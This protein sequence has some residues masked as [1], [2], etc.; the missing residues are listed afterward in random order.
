L[1]P[2]VILAI[3]SLF[4]TS[5]SKR[6][7]NTHHPISVDTVRIETIR[8]SIIF[9]DTVIYKTIPGETVIDSVI[10]PCPEVLGY[11][12][13]KVYAETSLAKASAWWD[14]PN[15]KLELIQK[16]TT[17]E[18]RLDRALK[19]SYHWKTLYEK[20][21]IKPEPEKYIPGFYKFS[22]FAFIGIIIALIGYVLLKIFK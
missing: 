6:W 18:L 15:I 16:D 22:T 1:K 2:I 20:L 21:H 12:V 9:R 19:E 8:D 10:I 5:C 14:F 17:I 13:K 7:C 4:A 11:Q 3:L